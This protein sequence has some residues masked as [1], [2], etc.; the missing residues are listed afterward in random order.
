MG[1]LHLQAARKGLNDSLFAGTVFSQTVLALL[2][3]SCF[4]AYVRSAVSLMAW[5][6]CP[7]IAMN[8]ET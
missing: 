4:I 5:D 1:V 8:R 3:E 2:E 6:L 7:E